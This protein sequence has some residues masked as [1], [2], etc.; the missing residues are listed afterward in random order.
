MAFPVIAIFVVLLVGHCYGGDTYK[1]NVDFTDFSWVQD[2]YPSMV[3]DRKETIE[4]VAPP[5]A[6]WADVN[7]T[8]EEMV[9]A[10]GFPV[11]T[12]TVTTEDGY[13]LTLHRIPYGRSGPSE[14]RPAVFV[15]HGL[16]SSSADWI[17]SGVDKGLAYLLAD[18][19]YDV[20]L[21]NARGNTN[22]RN[23]VNLDIKEDKE[24]FWNFSWHEIGYYDLPAMIDYVLEETKQDKIFHIGHSQGTTSFYV[25][26]S[27]RPEYNAKI[28]A[29]F[30][31]SPVVYMNHL[32]SP[33]LRMA[34]LVDRPLQNFLDLVGV[35]EFLPSSEL[36]SNFA[37][38]FCADDAITQFLCKDALFALC[39]F[40]RK[41]MNATLLP[42]L[43]AH[44]PAGSSTR[45]LVHYGQEINSG[46][47][48]R[49]DKGLLGNKASYGSTK[50]PNYDLKKVTTPV[51]FFYSTNDWMSAETDVLKLEK[52][53][54]NFKGKFLNPDPKWNH[55]DYVYGIDA[56]KYVYTRV[57]SLMSRH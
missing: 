57:I 38:Q 55:L 40:S 30:S 11:E 52:L 3:R 41:Q 44:T 47:F 29:H 33:M 7:R 10:R 2:S 21:G 28:R 46:R 56:A 6:E 49:Y 12:H 18:K 20:W 24:D 5:G 53:L 54:P 15:M 27:S 42:I 26:A 16:L 19:G 50:P 9:Q 37:I 32:V 17:I 39:G 34:A 36:L 8:F 23:H 31:L 51:Y 45:Q 14:N 1:D 48:R 25:M 43:V 35:Y 22:C 4:D 13:I